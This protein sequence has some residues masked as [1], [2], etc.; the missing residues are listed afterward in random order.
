MSRGWIGVDLDGTL[1][2]YE[3]WTGPASIGKPIPAM[4]A[5]VQQWH[6]DGKEVRIFT[7]RAYPLGYVTYPYN[8]DWKPINYEQLIAKLAIE[9]I[10]AWQLEHLG[11][12]VPI[13]CVKDYH[14]YE[15]WDD[16]AVQVERN[17]GRRMDNEPE[18]E[19]TP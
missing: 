4:V 15:L 13:T 2:H 18:G 8:P 16:R 14:M 19:A 3:S 6:R 10:F 5:R 9:A 7:A 17:T 1:A 11:F 12:A